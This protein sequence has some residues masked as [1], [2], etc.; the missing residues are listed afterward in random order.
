MSRTVNNITIICY[1][2]TSNK[3]RS[4]IDKCLKDFG[5]R[6][7]FSLFLCRLNTEGIERCRTKLLEILDKFKDET[8]AWDSLIILEWLNPNNFDCLLGA[9]IDQTTQKFAIF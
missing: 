4:K 6:I 3:L 7:Q 8:E 9:K 5:V 1:D 2:I